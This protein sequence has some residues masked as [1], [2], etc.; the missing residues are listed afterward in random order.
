MSQPIGQGV[1]KTPGEAPTGKRSSPS[2]GSRPTTPIYNMPIVAGVKIIE[3]A[4]TKHRSGSRKRSNLQRKPQ[5]SQTSTSGVT[6]TG[7]QDTKLPGSLKSAHSIK[8]TILTTQARESRR[9]RNLLWKRKI[10]RWMI[11]NQG[12][13][14][15][16]W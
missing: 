4:E 8:V 9:R 2:P 11:K 12:H 14:R 6:T 5:K 1:F 13:Q 7:S 16:L 3:R 10:W 15:V